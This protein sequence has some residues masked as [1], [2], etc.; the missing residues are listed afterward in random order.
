[1]KGC[2]AGTSS[3]VDSLLQTT[4]TSQF[5]DQMKKEQTLSDSVVKMDLNVAMKDGVRL[6]YCF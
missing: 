2:F 4:A 3:L 5:R 6:V 1:V